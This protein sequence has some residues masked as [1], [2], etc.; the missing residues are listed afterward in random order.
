MGEPDYIGVK[1][2]SKHGVGGVIFGENKACVPTVFR[3]EW[4]QW[5][6][7]EVDATNSGRGG[8]LTNS[9]LE[10][11]GL[12]LLW[13][14]MEEVCQFEPADHAALFS[15]NDPTVSWVDRLACRGSKVADQLIRA[16]VLRLKEQR[17]SPL[18]P[19]HIKGDQNSM[20][21]IPSRSWGSEPKWYCKTEEDLLTLF[22]NSFPIPGQHSWTVFRPSRE[23]QSRIL[24]VLQMKVLQMEEW[25]RLP[26]AGRHIGKS[27][28]PIAKLWEWTLTFRTLSSNELTQPSSPSQQE[29][30]QDSTA[31]AVLSAVER[32]R[33]LSRPLTRRLQWQQTENP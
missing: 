32:Y 30:G 18:T 29:C 3:M 19:Q 26:R 9:D 17:V 20:T 2:A 22:N 31:Q 24:S 1:D 33:R 8:N 15:D 16:L 6:K 7:D 10:M 28:E 12:L 23:I 27:G 5:V 11:A 4:P 14:I 21:D 13:L 25:R